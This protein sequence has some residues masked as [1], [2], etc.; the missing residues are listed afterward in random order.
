M[1]RSGGA[2]QLEVPAPPSAVYEQVADVTTIGDRSEEC[3]H[4]AWL[5]GADPGQVGAR[6]RGRNRFGIARW[7]RVCEVTEAEPGQRFAF[8]T[9][10]ERIDLSRADSTRWSF[11]FEPTA[12]GCLV[13]HEYRIERMPLQP[14]R[15]LYGRFL[16]HHRD[17]R[18]HM[19]RTLEALR[20]QFSDLPGDPIAQRPR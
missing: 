20:D 7:S 16:P 4:A 13:T 15:W 10:P 11:T 8:R 9:I 5:P 19:R 17:M 6:F 14:F 3:H 1:W 18:P 2:V 12:D